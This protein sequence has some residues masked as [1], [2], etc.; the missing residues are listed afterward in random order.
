MELTNMS[1]E[2]EY[3]Q[4]DDVSNTYT[5]DVVETHAGNV[6]ITHSGSSLCSS[7]RRFEA[8]TSSIAA[9]LLGARQRLP[10]GDPEVRDMSSMQTSQRPPAFAGVITE[11]L[12]DLADLVNEDAAEDE[13]QQQQQ[14]GFRGMDASMLT[15]LTEETEADLASNTHSRGVLSASL[16]LPGQQGAPLLPCAAL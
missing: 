8:C 4:P 6:L 16:P 12:P 14:R 9:C 10:H 3:A 5:G 1:E 13:R 15:P 7:I 2:Y 11:G